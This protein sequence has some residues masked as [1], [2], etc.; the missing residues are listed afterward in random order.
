MTTITTDKKAI[1][2]GLKTMADYRILLQ[3]KKE[4]FQRFA[5]GACDMRLNKTL[6]KY[7]EAAKAYFFKHLIAA[8]PDEVRHF[9]VEKGYG[10]RIYKQEKEELEWLGR[11]YRNPHFCYC[12]SREDDMKRGSNFLIIECYFNQSNEKKV[13]DKE[14]YR[15]LNSLAK[16]RYKGKTWVEYDAKRNIAKVS[17]YRRNKVEGQPGYTTVLEFDMTDEGIYPILYWMT[18]YDTTYIG[19]A[20]FVLKPKL[21]RAARD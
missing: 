8:Q 4:L 17:I 21:K 16:N 13:I 6:R 15:K 14:T 9:K 7:P 5:T 20:E 2:A 10:S 1:D 19:D 11:F 12:Y 18:D 3:E